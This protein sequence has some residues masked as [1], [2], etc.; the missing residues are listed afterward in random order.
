MRPRESRDP[1]S[2]NTSIQAAAQPCERDQHAIAGGLL[3]GQSLVLR[4]ASAG[5][6][7]SEVFS[8]LLTTTEEISEGWACAVLLFDK[9]NELRPAA[10]PSLPAPYLDALCSCVLDID[11]NPTA[12]LFIEI[13]ADPAWSSLRQAALEAG[14]HALWLEPITAPSGELLGI[15]STSFYEVRTPA[16]SETLAVNFACQLAATLIQQRKTEDNLQHHRASLTDFADVDSSCFWE[17]DVEGR[18]VDLVGTGSGDWNLS[19]A[20]GRT[21]REITESGQNCAPVLW[22]DLDLH[23][24][25]E[26]FHNIIFTQSNL[27]GEDRYFT[28]SG[29]PVCDAQGQTIGSRGTVQDVTALKGTEQNLQDAKEHA[30]LSNRSKSE[31]LAN[32]S[33]ELR[34]PLNAI[35]GFSE[36]LLSEMFGPI[37]NDQYLE[38]VK[39]INESGSHL[40]SL[41]NDVLDL[42]KI[43]AGRFSIVEE[44]LAIDDLVRATVRLVKP[45]ADE[46]RLK[47][48]FDSPEDLPRFMGD[49]RAIKQIVLNLL[50]N[51]VKFT[52]PDGH[53]SIS[54]RITDDG[55]IEITVSDSGIGIPPDQL[56][57]VKEPFVQVERTIDR[58]Y[59]GTGL[60]LPLTNRLIE[61]HQGTLTLRSEPDVGTTA[62]VTFPAE[63]TIGP[64]AAVESDR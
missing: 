54:L 16:Q 8:L 37:D 46:A 40:L 22:G 43:E 59:E 24:R 52:P 18:F 19:E 34:T 13:H 56:A 49:A 5:T 38:Y 53:V 44:Q 29:R 42:S 62:V 28:V 33:H 48:Q 17:M 15:L 4:L 58:R 21:T 9:A 55:S 14:I 31:F 57:A 47:V 50:S 51:A 25:K 27:A 11:R 63:R 2:I 30:E 3:A 10:G 20:I 32:M 45:K 1:A 60:G 61:L 36:I 6:A 41:I 26:E 7:L 12:G 39:D 35:I 64:D 23:T